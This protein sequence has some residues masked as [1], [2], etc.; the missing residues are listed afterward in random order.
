MPRPPVIAS[1]AFSPVTP[2]QRR[3]PAT[4][5]VL[6]FVPPD[7]DYVRLPVGPGALHAMR[8]GHGGPAV[9]LVHGFTTSAPLWQRVAPILLAN[10]CQVIVPDL[11]GFGES[12]RPVGGPYTVSAQARYLDRALALL[13]INRVVAVGQDL[14]CVVLRRLVA[15]RPER[16]AGMIHCSPT[17]ADEPGGPE[18]DA[19]RGQTGPALLEISSRPLG[20]VDL[21]G[22]VLRAA[23][24]EPESMPDRLVAR[25]SAPY[26]GSQ[27]ARHLL[28]LAR[29][30]GE[31]ED[32][33]A[34]ESSE[35]GTLRVTG[36]DDPMMA[37]ASASIIRLPSALRLLPVERPAPLAALI[38]ER[39]EAMRDSSAAL[40][41]RGDSG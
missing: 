38:M 27:G 41:V 18:I 7:C 23:V 20:V 5:S 10:G 30:V 12:D 33:L 40:E 29:A 31:E 9:L 37:P 21:L 32:A 39:V 25:F 6:P 34:L 16:V 28:D 24:A 4:R 1:P 15:I 13:R 22:P 11:L 35:S 17:P 8:Y 36:A 2:P 14:G 26:T 3:L 19:V